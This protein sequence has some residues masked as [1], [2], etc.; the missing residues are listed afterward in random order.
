MDDLG[1]P[2]SF[3]NTHIVGSHHICTPEMVGTQHSKYHHLVSAKGEYHPFDLHPVPGHRSG[4]RC[5]YLC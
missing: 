1:V 4:L 2:I 5:H 3:G